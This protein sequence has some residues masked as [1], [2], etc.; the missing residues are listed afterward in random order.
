MLKVELPPI[1]VSIFLSIGVIDLS[2][3]K[4]DDFYWNRD[5][6]SRNRY[7]RKRM[8]VGFEKDSRDKRAQAGYYWVGPS[9]ALRVVPLAGGFGSPERLGPVRLKKVERRINRPPMSSPAKGESRQRGS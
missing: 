7:N 9:A 6:L 3:D 1:G 2:L 5:A 8:A 4:M